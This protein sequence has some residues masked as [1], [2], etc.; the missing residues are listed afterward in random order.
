MNQEKY[1][2]AEGFFLR[3]LGIDEKACGAR[4]LDA[5]TDLAA[6]AQLYCMQERY[7]EAKRLAERAGSIVEALPADDS[8]EMATC[9]FALGRSSSM[10]DD[11]AA[12]VGFFRRAAEIEAVVYGPRHREVGLDLHEQGCAHLTIEEYV[13]AEECLR[14]ALDILERDPGDRTMV[15]NCAYSLAEV[16]RPQGR[17]DEAET[18][19]KKA[20]AIDEKIYG[21]EHAEVL[22]SIRGLAGLYREAERLDDAERLARRAAAMSEKLNG[23]DDPELGGDLFGLAETLVEKE[24]FKEAELLY[25]RV[26]AIDTKAYGA[27]HAEVALDL[28]SL[29]M[30]YRQ[31]ERYAEALD[32]LTNSVKTCEATVGPDDPLTGVSLYHR[33]GVY[34][35]LEKYV[36]AEAD[37]RR[38]VA[39]DVRAY[40]ENHS[41]VIEDLLALADVCVDAGKADEAR[42]VAAR[43]SAAV[44]VLY[45][46]NA[47]AL[48]SYRERIASIRENA[49][50]VR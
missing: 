32:C 41:E 19:Y 29:G 44:E 7:D 26:L 45:K 42:R 12:A 18:F 5:A 15:S 30:L 34:Q 4:S 33:A 35:D 47:E 6:L 13:E 49:G 11:A 20:M 17:W 31:Q 50:S 25:K 22:I 9:L 24:S 8:V 46:D 39:M 21:P 48:S 1:K 28:R 37:L 14:R 38:V 36:E 10:L 2:E 16:A 23:P 27:E 40:G 3:A 43:A